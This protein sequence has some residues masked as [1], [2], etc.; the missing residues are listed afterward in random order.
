MQ[1]LAKTLAARDN[2][3]PKEEPAAVEQEDQVAAEVRA[4]AAELHQEALEA[5]Q[6]EELQEDRAEASHQEGEAKEA[7]QQVQSP[8][9]KRSREQEELQLL[10]ETKEERL[11]R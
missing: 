4:A 7:C 1:E 3:L 6:E 11:L 5:G 9:G 8:I 10:L 2:S